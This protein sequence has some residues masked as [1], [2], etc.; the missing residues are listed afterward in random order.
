MLLVK[1]KVLNV[2]KAIQTR[3]QFGQKSTIF[4]TE[5]RTRVQFGHQSVYPI[6]LIKHTTKLKIETFNYTS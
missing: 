4:R 3:V 1:V 5:I 2:F 6:G